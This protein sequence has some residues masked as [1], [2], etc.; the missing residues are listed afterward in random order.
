M[1]RRPFREWGS[2]ALLYVDNPL[3][4]QMN[5]WKTHVVHIAGYFGHRLKINPY[6]I[7]DMEG[8]IV[9]TDPTLL[10]GKCDTCHG[11][12][13]ICASIEKGVQWYRLRRKCRPCG[14][15]IHLK[16]CNA[17][18]HRM[19]RHMAAICKKRGNRPLVDR[20]HSGDRVIRD[21]KDRLADRSPQERVFRHS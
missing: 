3:L 1:A 17:A 4:D 10:V 11:K 5:A 6:K 7:H 21:F 16:K 9:A 19:V 13:V 14:P 18:D 15:R 8:K 20:K 12:V 2:G